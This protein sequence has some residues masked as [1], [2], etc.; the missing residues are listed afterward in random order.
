MHGQSHYLYEASCARA[1]TKLFKSPAQTKWPSLDKGNIEAFYGCGGVGKGRG[2]R[3]LYQT[4]D[5]KKVCIFSYSSMRE[6]SNKRSGTRLKHGRVRFTCF[7]RT[8]LL[9]HILLISL[10]ILR[11]KRTVLQSNQTLDSL[12]RSVCDRTVS[13]LVIS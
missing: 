5:C 3:G 1:Q 9:C 12:A 8:R 4:L 2:A 6:Q 13:Y 11:K 7:A 10:L